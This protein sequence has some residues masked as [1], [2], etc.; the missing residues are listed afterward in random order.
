MNIQERS[1]VETQEKW[2]ESIQQIPYISFKEGWEVSIIPPFGGAMAR[3]LVREKS[4]QK[5]RV[6]V[7]LDY[8]DN[9]GCVGKPYWE[10]YPIGN[11]TARHLLNETDDLVKT[12]EQALI[13]QRE[14]V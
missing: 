1:I 11:D 13:E 14:E 3:F 5:G 9:L 7:Y 2:R 10:V 12:I 6:S 4:N 8:F